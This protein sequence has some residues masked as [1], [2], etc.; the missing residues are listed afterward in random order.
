MFLQQATVLMIR[1]IIFSPFADSMEMEKWTCIQQIR[2]IDDRFVFLNAL[3][4]LGTMY[5]EYIQ[6]YWIKSESLYVAYKI[7]IIIRKARG[8]TQGY[9]SQPA[10]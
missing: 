5:T 7:V 6:N 10:L 2:H 1:W 3:D 8:I 9:M 4:S